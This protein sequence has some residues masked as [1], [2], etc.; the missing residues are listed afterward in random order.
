MTFNPIKCEF[1]RITNKINIIPFTY[2]IDNS[3][4]REVTH[5]KYLGIVIDQHLNWNEHTKQAAS[6]ATR[7]NAF[8]HRN[9]YQCPPTIKCNMYKAMVRPIME[10][11]SSV[12]DPHTCVNI[13][14]LEAVQR[15]ATR[16]CYK[17]F[18]RFSSVSTMLTDLNLPTLQSRRKKLKLQ[19][20]YKIIHRLADIPDDCLTP[21]PSFLRSGY[22][23]QLNTR[24]DSFIFSFFPSVI[25]LW[26]NL[27]Q[28][29][30]NAPTYTEFCNDLDTFI[31]TPV[32]YMIP[33][34][35]TI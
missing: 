32:H 24:V 13:N 3:T 9:L 31:I 29:I 16:M 25:K 14:Q 15:S 18:S 12:W 23:N 11:A 22:F 2:H 30:V 20:L 21:V 27:P 28:N 7:I 1:L 4:I 34:Q 26:N 6:K 35:Y 19:M 8:L 33:A 5:A 10:Y 17:D